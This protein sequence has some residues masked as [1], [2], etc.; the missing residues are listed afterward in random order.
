MTE[1]DDKFAAARERYAAMVAAD[2]ARV[3]QAFA[4]IPREA[5]LTDPPWTV[6]LPGFGGALVTSE[7][8]ELYCDGLVALCGE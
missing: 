4:E 1:K 6:F 8:F 3:Q 2:D 7:P 5:F